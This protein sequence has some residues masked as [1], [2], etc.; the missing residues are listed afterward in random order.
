MK[1]VT[2]CISFFA[3]ICL[4]TG[5]DNKIASPKA[6]ENEKIN[7]D[8]YEFTKKFDNKIQPD[9]KLNALQK[10]TVDTIISGF[11]TFLSE[12][13]EKDF[14]TINTYAKK[15][16]WKIIQNEEKDKED[17]YYEYIA[18]LT[19]GSNVSI[20]F[21]NHILSPNRT[22]HDIYIWGLTEKQCNYLVNYYKYEEKLKVEVV[23]YH[24]SREGSSTQSSSCSAL[25]K[26]QGVEVAISLEHN[27]EVYGNDYPYFKE[28]IN[29]L[30][31]KNYEQLLTEYYTRIYFSKEPVSPKI[32]RDGVDYA[33]N[34]VNGHITIGYVN[35]EK[36]KN[37]LYHLPEN[38]KSKVNGETQCSKEINTIEFFK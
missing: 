31:N 17:P 14:P 23:K 27:S 30:I 2:Q 3:F 4:L 11:S 5:C 22:I 16:D 6:F 38:I 37:I 20:L 10:N 36:C 33:I 18:K 34:T 8:I 1:R 26:P 24:H 32:F 21:Q 28:Q 7:A 19:D 15:H 25:N 12:K 9:I 13:K 29:K 35:K